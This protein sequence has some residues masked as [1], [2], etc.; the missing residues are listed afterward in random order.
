MINFPQKKTLKF[1]AIFGIPF[2]FLRIGEKEA[3]FMRRILFATILLAGMIYGSPAAASLINDE[4]FATTESSTA[5]TAVGNV[6]MEY[7]PGE[8]FEVAAVDYCY[9]GSIA[10]ATTGETVDLFV[11]C[12]EDGVEQNI[13]VA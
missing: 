13:D 12:A 8:T 2:A 3:H 10:D 4:P 6:I 9:A 5:L 7:I 1:N 11:L